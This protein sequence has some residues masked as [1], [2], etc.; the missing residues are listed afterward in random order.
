MINAFGTGLVSSSWFRHGAYE[1]ETKTGFPGQGGTV[2]YRIFVVPP[3]VPTCPSLIEMVSIPSEIFEKAFRKIS[4]SPFLLFLLWLCDFL[5]FLL[6]PLGTL[7][8]NTLLVTNPS[9]KSRKRFE[10]TFGRLF[11]S[12][13][14]ALRLSFLFFGAFIEIP[15]KFSKIQSSTTHTTCANTVID[16]GAHIIPTSHTT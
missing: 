10:N 11:F 1:H 4:L 7:R 2:K 14:L 12:F 15:T 13:F 6:E 5:L 8:D 16:V 9:E 3:P